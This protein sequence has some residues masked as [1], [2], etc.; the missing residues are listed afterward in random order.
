MEICSGLRINP[1][2]LVS[3]FCLAS[4]GGGTTGEASDSNIELLGSI[5]V[6]HAEDVGCLEG[7]KAFFLNLG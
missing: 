3:P 2:P 5:L 4:L 7:T 6:F 1:W